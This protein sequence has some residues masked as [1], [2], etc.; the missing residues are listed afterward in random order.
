MSRNV[1]EAILSFQKNMTERSLKLIPYG[2]A[3][4]DGLRAENY[5]YVDK[6][7]YIEELEK[8]GCKYP[9]IVRPR[10][11]G[12]SLFV[13]TLKAYYDQAAAPSFEKNFAGTYI[14]EH[15]TPL[16][17]SFRVLKFDFSGIA[18]GDV[19]ENFT[20][21]TLDAISD[22]QN[23]YPNVKLQEL[24]TRTHS[25]PAKL[26]TEFFRTVASDQEKIYVIIDEYDQFANELLARDK[27]AFLRITSSKGFLKDFYAAL[28]TATADSIVAR[29]FITGVTTISLDSLTSGFNIS[30][31]ISSYPAF[32]GMFGFTDEEL[33]GLIEEVLDIQKLGL[34]VEDIFVRMK[35][36]YNGYRF[37]SASS[38]SVF[39]A[40]MCLYYLRQVSVFGAEPEVL[41][42][43]AFSADISKIHSILSLGNAEYVQQVVGK[44]TSHQMIDSGSL[45]PVVNLHSIQQLSDTQLLT[46]MVYFGFLTYAERDPNHLVVPNRAVALQFFEYYFAVLRDMPG[47]LVRKSLFEQ[48]FPALRKGDPEPFVQTVSKA[49]RMGCG[50]HSAAHLRESDFQTAL[51]TAATFSMDFEARA[52]VE[53][54]GVGY[55]DLILTPRNKA[56]VT[57]L[58]ELKHLTRKEAAGKGALD[59][60]KEKASGQLER[61]AVG[62]GFD[63]LERL[64]KV[65][66]VYA[67]TDLV[68]VSVS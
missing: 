8:S 35:S 68:S 30:E 36:W 29:V 50:I 19:V 37:S 52:E 33:T 64:K 27:E 51:L 31:N 7:R 40:S 21:K 42:D 54:H 9:L 44:A 65:A 25:S 67:G 63:R 5:V 20:A 11:F 28:K 48:T 14:G 61:Y 12:K 17:N 49:V 55:A 58:F 38:T 62:L 39:N 57:Y 23:R 3:A 6:T 16:A 10:R 53:V 46:V 59:E 2:Q 60:A 13:T 4:F 56:G 47:D 22:F 18:F 1:Q 24:L 45:A 43:P 34:S 32:A 41:L 26:F 66:L 15:K